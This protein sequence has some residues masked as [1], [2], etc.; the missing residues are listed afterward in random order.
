MKYHINH[1]KIALRNISHVIH[2]VK[3][4]K[5]RWYK[6]NWIIVNTSHAIYKTHG[7][8]GHKGR[9]K[10]RHKLWNDAQHKY[11]ILKRY[12]IPNEIQGDSKCKI[13]WYYRILDLFSV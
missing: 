4:D 11:P 7:A 12:R 9:Q 2:H 13:K 5:T 1:N 8:Y 10:I 3:D 6:V